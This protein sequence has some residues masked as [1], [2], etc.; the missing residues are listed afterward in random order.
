MMIDGGW[1]NH[2]YVQLGYQLAAATSTIAW[3]FVVTYIILFALDKVPFLK[4]RLSEEEEELG[5][6]AAQI[7]EF[8]YQDSQIYIPEPVRS[9]K[10]G[11]KAAESDD[12]EAVPL[13]KDE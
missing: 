7:G 6:D 10:T 2:H 12:A 8:T 4:L 9:V 3:A 13:P 11:S 1:L 5:T